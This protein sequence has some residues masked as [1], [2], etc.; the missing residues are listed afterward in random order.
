MRRW[1]CVIALLAGLEG[2]QYVWLARLRRPVPIE[3]VLPRG[4]GERAIPEP[5]W[6]I[7]P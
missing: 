2:E 1:F 4:V 3:R 6:W 5:S 7:G